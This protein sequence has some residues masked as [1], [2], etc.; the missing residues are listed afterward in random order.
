[1]LSG[2]GFNVM[3]SWTK[4]MATLLMSL[5]LVLF[6]LGALLRYA[7]GSLSWFGNLPGDIHYQTENTRVFIPITTMLLIS[8]VGSFV[9]SFWGR[10]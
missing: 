3:N 6:I 7:P 9:L 4:H 2:V 10:K 1:M 8:I 5:G